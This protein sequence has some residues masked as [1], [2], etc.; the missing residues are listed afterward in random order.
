MSTLTVGV[1]NKETYNLASP[2][3]IVSTARANITGN[4]SAD[5]V[6]TTIKEYQF[7]ERIPLEGVAMANTSNIAGY[8]QLRIIIESALPVINESDLWFQI[9]NDGGTVYANSNN[10]SAMYS[11][12]AN[13]TVETS[14]T[15]DSGTGHRLTRWGISNLANSGGLSGIMDFLSNEPNIDNRFQTIL[16][17]RSGETGAGGPWNYMHRGYGRFN[18]VAP[19]TNYRFKMTLNGSF[20]NGTIIV[21][22]IP[23]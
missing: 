3:G 14:A 7:I 10:L 8:S 15:G 20:A 6:I 5:R 11:Y 21:E 12:M 9:S 16:H 4:V 13:I 22:G 18:R 17:Y 23:K 2:V 19:A 1:V